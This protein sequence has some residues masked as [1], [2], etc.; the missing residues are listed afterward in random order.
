MFERNTGL[1]ALL[2]RPRPSAWQQFLAQPCV[3]LVRKIYA[4]RQVIPFQPISPVRIV[5]ISDTHNSQPD[6]PTGEILIHAGDLTQSGTLRE[7]QTALDWLNSL[8]HRKKV[9]VAGNHDSLLVMEHANADSSAIRW[10]DIIYLNDESVTLDCA[11]GRVFKVYGSPLSPRHGSW[12]F[13]YPRTQDVWHGK[14]PMDTDIL[15]THAPPKAHLD[16]GRLGCTFLLEELWRTKPRL[17][18]SATFMKDMGESGSSLMDCRERMR[19]RLLQAGV[20]GI[21]DEWCTNSLSHGLHRRMRPGP[22]W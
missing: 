8:P 2:D 1:N 5:C 3:F 10:G 7:L 15:I 4:W 21:S 19:R 9:V 14:V 11:G 6:I 18:V 22:S 16:L 13:Q 20:F 12:A 17:H